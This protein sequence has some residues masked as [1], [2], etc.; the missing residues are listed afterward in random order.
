MCVWES[1]IGLIIS[2]WCCKIQRRRAVKE[3][4]LIF[5]TF[6]RQDPE[7]GETRV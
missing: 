3:Q 1:R 5:H 2:R 4:R 7:E 6:R